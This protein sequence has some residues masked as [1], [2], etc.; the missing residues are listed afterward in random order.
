MRKAAMVSRALVAVVAGVGLLALASP[1]V[2]KEE[3]A[4]G[5]CGPSFC[6]GV[7]TPHEIALLSESGPVSG[8]PAAVAPFYVLAF[9]AEAEGREVSWR[10]YY[11]PSAALVRSDNGSGEARWAELASPSQRKLLDELAAKVTPFPPPTLLEAHIGGRAVSGDLATYLD[12]FALPS[13]AAPVPNASDWVPIDLRSEKPSPWT[14]GRWDLA[15]SSEARVLERGTRIVA[16]PDDLAGDLDVRRA[17]VEDDGSRPWPA[18]LAVLAAIAGLAA[19]L[20]WLAR[21]RPLPGPTPP[22]TSAP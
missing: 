19:A 10:L 17:L 15:Y 13:S 2:A 18:V 1:A 20:A 4:V 22:S 16:L 12:L 9:S 5:L 11:V 8:S 7:I 3:R 6:F 14:D 21:K